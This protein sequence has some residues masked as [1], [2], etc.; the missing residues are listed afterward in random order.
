MIIKSDSCFLELRLLEI[1]PDLLPTPGDARFAV[2]AK[3]YEFSGANTI[4]I[5]RRVIDAFLENLI[6]LERY[7]KGQ[8]ELKS[9]SPEEFSLR[10]FFF[11]K[12]GPVAIQGC[13]RKY[14]VGR[15]EFMLTPDTSQLNQLF[16]DFRILLEV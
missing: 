14:N 16:A 9:M 12:A 1:I 8:A 11:D 7:R 5:A 4:W 13:L 10:V 2:K 3:T 15:V 6:V